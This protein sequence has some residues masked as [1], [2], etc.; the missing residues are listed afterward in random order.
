MD[1]IVTD[2]DDAVA[3]LQAGDSQKA[4]ALLEQLDT[5]TEAAN[6]ASIAYGLTVCGE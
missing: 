3:A 5:D 2:V 1:V 6:A 4:V